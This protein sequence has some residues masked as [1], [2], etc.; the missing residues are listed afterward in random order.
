MEDCKTIERTDPSKTRQ[1]PP[2]RQEIL[3]KFSQ[4][5]ER[6]PFE[7]VEDLLAEA[8]TVMNG[9]YGEATMR[10]DTRVFRLRQERIVYIDGNT[11]LGQSLAKA[12]TAL[13]SKAYCQRLFEVQRVP[14][15][16]TL[17]GL[18]HN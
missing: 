14:K 8:R 11:F 10:L 7:D 17:A 15:Q 2:K 18:T 13:L 16:A 5:D 9:I 6:I 1:E 4:F 12:F 3:Y